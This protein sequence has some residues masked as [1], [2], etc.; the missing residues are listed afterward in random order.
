VKG[1]GIA[2][3]AK[4]QYVSDPCRGQRERI[5]LEVVAAVRAALAGA[6][7]D[8]GG[9]VTLMELR[10]CF[11]NRVADIAEACS[12][13]FEQPKPPWEQRKRDHRD[14][15]D[16]PWE[17]FNG[18]KE[19]RLWCCAELIAQFD[20]V[21]CRYCRTNCGASF[22]NSSRR[23]RVHSD[24]RGVPNRRTL[25]RHPFYRAGSAVSSFSSGRL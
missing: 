12:D 25:D 16:A 1:E 8:R 11:G 20:R 15:G 22:R 24:R 17:R 23:L 5:V 3:K 13:T 2:G 14:C 4:T 21:A 7:T 10:R 19:G 9:P 18:G 6:R